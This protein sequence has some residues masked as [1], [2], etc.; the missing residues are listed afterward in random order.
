MT[1]SKQATKQAVPAQ[2][3]QLYQ[4]LLQH[5]L[6]SAAPIIGGV[7][8]GAKRELQERSNTSRDMRERN[9]L[10]DSWLLLQQHEQALR[11]AFPLRLCKL[12]GIGLV[13]GELP[14]ASAEP[15]GVSFE[16]LELM[17]ENQIKESVVIAKVQEKAALQLE[18]MQTDLT[19][20]LSTVQG[21]GVLHV[22]ANPLRYSNYIQAMR[23][24][25]AELD[26][27][28]AL[29]LDWI[30]LMGDGLIAE[31]KSLYR[32]WLDRL[33][34]QGVK[35]AGYAIRQAPTTGSANSTRSTAS[36]T[37]AS[38]PVSSAAPRADSHR[39]PSY[40]LTLERLRSL[41]S[42]ELGGDSMADPQVTR[43]EAF[44]QDFA[45]QFEISGAGRI[46]RPVLRTD[47]QA[48]VPA[49]FEAL[50]EMDQTDAMVQ[51]LEQRVRGSAQTGQ[52]TDTVDSIEQEKTAVWQLAEQVAQRLSLEVV[53]MMMRGI[54]Q[55]QRMLAGVRHSLRRLEPAMMR[56]ALGEPRMFTDRHHPA[57]RMLNEIAQRSLAYANDSAEGVTDFLAD[58]D[59]AVSLLRSDGVY[60]AQA[61]EQILQGMQQR[62][63]QREQEAIASREQA[64]R[65]LQKAEQRNLLA[66]TIAKEV[67]G[68]PDIGKI[69]PVVVQFLQG[70]WA[71]VVA[72]A[73]LE[74]GPRSELANKYQALISALLWSTHPELPVQ[75]LAKFTR[76]VPVLLSNLR[77]GLESIGMPAEQA[78]P[79][80]EAL[81]SLQQQVFERVR[82]ERDAL[83]KQRQE[84]LT[85]Q[86]V[87]PAETPSDAVTTQR[88]QE[89]HVTD[90]GDEP[91]LVPSEV[92]QSNFVSLDSSDDSPD[93]SAPYQPPVVQPE[94][95][96]SGVAFLPIGTWVEL[97]TAEGLIRTQLT[98]ASLHETLFLFSTAQGKTQSMTRRTYDKLEQSGKLRVLADQPLVDGALD[99]VAQQAMRNS[100]SASD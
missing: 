18:A 90:I 74:H 75:D 77:E 46:E 36:A 41:L 23:A 4:S 30:T 39:S 32:E 80:L 87:S 2:Y 29:R 24:A 76:V 59:A 67:Q 93:Q 53:E 19:A 47:F 10:H 64:V 86:T 28:P 3:E 68:L 22:Q 65:A 69:P 84:A 40:M 81:M 34:A 35:P 27:A 61:F 70:T 51:R 95:K 33:Q 96:P 11:D 17:D 73:R 16:L 6:Q 8:Q 56:L 1:T 31:L 15:V 100:L 89:L 60:T 79:F 94:G 78:G 82:K 44:A 99:A 21:Y 66:Q 43:V 37:T 45:R 49:A 42:G 92:Q 57:R 62:W 26:V 38:S 83:L 50:R 12:L 88:P 72:H 54:V 63:L 71:Q 85:Q 5:A 13:S 98:W 91:W 14:A 55:D 25:M 20:L 97:E 48:T 52:L 9:Q 58:V 7:V